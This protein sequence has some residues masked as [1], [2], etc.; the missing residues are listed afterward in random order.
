MLLGLNL[1]VIIDEHGSVSI[2]QVL[3]HSYCTNLILLC[4]ILC[5]SSKLRSSRQNSKA[6]SSADATESNFLG[7]TRYTDL[8]F[9]AFFALPP[10]SS[11]VGLLLFLA[12]SIPA[13]IL[14]PWVFSA[15]VRTPSRMW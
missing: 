8:Y 10:S 12:F 13:F 3:Q 7:L 14:A 2:L 15:M 5:V 4:R 1:T 9:L 6:L 11:S